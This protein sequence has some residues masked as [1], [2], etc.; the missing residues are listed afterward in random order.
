MV[1]RALDLLSIPQGDTPF[2]DCDDGYVTHLY[3]K[4]ILR[5]AGNGTFAPDSPIT[6]AEMAAI[7]W[8]MYN[9]DVTEGT[10]R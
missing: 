5:G 7:I 4:G 9:L 1:A 3:E 6:R 2:T 10:F 8:R